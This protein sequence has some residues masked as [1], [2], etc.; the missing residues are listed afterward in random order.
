MKFTLMVP[1][2]KMKWRDISIILK[3][4]NILFKLSSKC[5]IL[6]AEAEVIKISINKEHSKYKQKKR[7]IA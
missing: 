5:F 3:I 7:K 2:H 6:T 4:K 1:L